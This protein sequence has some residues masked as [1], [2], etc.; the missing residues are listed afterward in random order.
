M[1]TNRM[2]KEGL[3][4]IRSCDAPVVIIGPVPRDENDETSE[5]LIGY[6]LAL[7][8]YKFRTDGLMEFQGK[9]G[10][11]HV[12][13]EDQAM[14]VGMRLARDSFPFSDGWTGQSCITCPVHEWQVEEKK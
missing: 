3:E 1:T 5:R 13:N 4:A 10:F 12:L 14:G 9:A 2:S 11:T 7:T 6:A 8:A